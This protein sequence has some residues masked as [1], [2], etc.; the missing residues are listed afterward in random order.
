M[1]YAQVICYLPLFIFCGRHLL[2]SK[3]RPSNI[4]GAAGAQEEVARIVGQVRRRWPRVRSL[5]RADGGFCRDS[6]MACRAM[7]GWSRRSR[8]NWRLRRPKAA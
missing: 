3:R 8:A 4:D 6:L 2:A 7:H 1:P 5:L